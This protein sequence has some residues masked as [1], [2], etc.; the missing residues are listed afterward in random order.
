M[1]GVAD[2][3]DHAALRR[4]SLKTSVAGAIISIVFLDASTFNQ[5]A[6]KHL[7]THT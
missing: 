2:S 7:Q 1:Q 5:E 6:D 4:V 3:K